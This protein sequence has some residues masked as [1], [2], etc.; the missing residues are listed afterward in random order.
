MKKRKIRLTRYGETYKRFGPAKQKWLL[1]LI[2]ECNGGCSTPN[3]LTL[4]DTA[5]ILN[6]SKLEL[7]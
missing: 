5:K 2:D 1:D 6:V 3:R 7:A 4:N